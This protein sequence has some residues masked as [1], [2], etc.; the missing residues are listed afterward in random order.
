M[1]FFSADHHFYHANII[2]Y[3]S[4]PF[5]SVEEM[6]EEMIARWNSTVGFWVLTSIGSG[7]RYANS[8][9]LAA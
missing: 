4:R 9:P 8:T 2:R 6:N 5:N 3:C 7:R 1:I